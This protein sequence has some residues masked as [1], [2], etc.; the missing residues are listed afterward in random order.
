MANGCPLAAESTAS[1]AI[2]FELL[3]GLDSFEAV[4]NDSK[5]NLSL[6]GNVQ[7]VGRSY[8]ANAG[9]HRPI[10]ATLPAATT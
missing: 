8:P 2:A 1:I 5:T 10:A 7:E 3:V 9:S 6:D 4:W